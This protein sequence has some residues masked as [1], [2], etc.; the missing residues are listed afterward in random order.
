MVETVIFFITHTLKNFDTHPS[1]IKINEF[2]FVEVF[3]SVASSEIIAISSPWTRIFQK[4]LFP[5]LI[6]DLPAFWGTT[7][8]SLPCS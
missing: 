5:Q 6:K 7:E 1:R 3:S 2:S 4:L 8:C